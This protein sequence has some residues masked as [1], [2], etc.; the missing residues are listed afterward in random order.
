MAED[1]KDRLCGA[2]LI[3]LTIGTVVS[4]SE[5][6]VN[7]KYVSANDGGYTDG[8]ITGKPNEEIG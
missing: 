5:K 1:S 8:R 2:A 6:V 7:S 3:F 4:L